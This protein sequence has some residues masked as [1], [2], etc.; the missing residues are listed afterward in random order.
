MKAWQV[1]RWCV[2][3]P[4]N[5]LKR[6]IAGGRRLLLSAR[7][8][9]LCVLLAIAALV[10][11]YVLSD[12]YTPFTTDAYVQAFVIQVAA[13]VEGQVV[14]V[15]VQENQAIRKGD[16]LFE[17]DPRPFEHRVAVLEA[18]LAQATQQVAQMESEL[19]ASRADDARIVAE[20]AYA[21]AVHEQ[22]TQ[23]RKQDATTDR[24]YLDAVQ[25]YRAAQAD[26]ER[27]RATTRKGEQALAARIG[28]EHAIVAEVKAQLAEAKLNLSWTRIYAPA[29]GY[30]TNVQLREGSYVHVGTPVLTCIDSD[31]WW[32]VANYRENSLEYLQPG[33]RVGL[34]FNTYPGRLFPGVVKT[35]G[36]GVYQGQAAP[37]G[38]LPAVTEP[39]N[40]I[41]LAQRFQV[42]VSPQMPAGYPLRIGATASVAVYPREEYWLNGVTDAWHTVVAAFDYLR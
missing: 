42:W 27:S 8:W 3:V 11:Y 33:Q 19:A 15:H 36:W 7:V 9:V 18:K 20:E 31:Q 35:V 24:K 13:R 5:I 14:Q 28:G 37:S 34:S 30:V 41:R 2:L 40:W 16:L 21:R 38:H 12:R 22:E 1:F 39:Q 4:W 29:N 10:A 25:K 32:V 23:I 26:R 6:L 17:I